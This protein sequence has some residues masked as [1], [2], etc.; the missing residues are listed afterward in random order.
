LL[1]SLNKEGS[2][3]WTCNTHEINIRPI[4]KN[5]WGA[6]KDNIKINF[7]EIIWEIVD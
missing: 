4:C 2:N 6:W 5:N 1:K 7:E 3:S